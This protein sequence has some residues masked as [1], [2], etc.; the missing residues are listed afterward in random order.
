MPVLWPLFH[1]HPSH[2]LCKKNQAAKRDIPF[3]S[4]IG[5]AISLLSSVYGPYSRDLDFL[6]V[7]SWDAPF[8]IVI[9]CRYAISLVLIRISLIGYTALLVLLHRGGTGKTLLLSCISIFADWW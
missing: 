3:S 8:G 2:F 9:V 4:L 5:I 6:G 1:W 7:G